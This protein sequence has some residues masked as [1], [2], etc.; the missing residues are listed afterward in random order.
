MVFDIDDLLCKVKRKAGKNRTTIQKRLPGSMVI[1]YIHEENGDKTLFD[2][3]FFPNYGELFLNLLSWGWNLDFFC[4]SIED[5][6]KVVIGAFLKHALKPYCQDVSSEVQELMEQRVR[7]FSKDHIVKRTDLSP[8]LNRKH[9]CPGHPKRKDLRK[10]EIPLTQCILVDNDPRYSTGGEQYPCLRGDLPGLC[11]N[12]YQTLNGK[13][14]FRD[15]IFSFRK[16]FTLPEG[17]YPQQDYAAFQLGVFLDCKEMMEKDNTELRPAL[18]EVLR[19]QWPVH[20]KDQE[21]GPCLQWGFDLDDSEEGHKKLSHWI[22]KGRN[23][24]KETQLRMKKTDQEN[25]VYEVIAEELYGTTDFEKLTS[26]SKS[27]W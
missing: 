18:K 7:I 23:A 12:F 8:S 5:R 17:H 27:W 19:I 26:G 22:A 3:V 14:V 15:S 24:I 13:R 1:P 10:L 21:M 2:H 4:D 6:N 16:G 11:N 25:D 9:E 20:K